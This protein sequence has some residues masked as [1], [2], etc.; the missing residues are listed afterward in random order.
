MYVIERQRERQ[1]ETEAE[2][3][4]G[5]PGGRPQTHDSLASILS[6]GITGSHYQARLTTIYHQEINV[7]VYLVSPSKPCYK[8]ALVLN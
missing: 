2:P 1:R 8:V 3:H 5:T 4:Y 6:A 7:S